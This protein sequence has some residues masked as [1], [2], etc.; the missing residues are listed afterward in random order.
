[1]AFNM[2]YRYDVLPDTAKPP[3]TKP[4]VHENRTEIA[5]IAPDHRVT[6]ASHL[7]P[8]AF[9]NV[10]SNLLQGKDLSRKAT[11][12]VLTVGF[13]QQPKFDY[14]V[15]VDTDK[16]DDSKLAGILTFFG[17]MHMKEPA[18]EYTKTF[19]FD[20]SKEFDVSKLG[21]DFKLLIVNAM[22]QPASELT[23]KKARIETRDF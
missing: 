7:V 2:D 8:L 19:T 20:I 21:S 11:I 17:A 22:G 16:P 13:K 1:M 14:E 9:T 3:A 15:Y 18:P 10:Q 4:V 5:S 6:K 12:L 23:I